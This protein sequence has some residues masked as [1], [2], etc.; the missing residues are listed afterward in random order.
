[1]GSYP[2]YNIVKSACKKRLM[3]LGMD[4]GTA[5]VLAR[6][7]KFW[8]PYGDR[9][10]IIETDWEELYNIFIQGAF[11][12]GF[13]VDKSIKESHKRGFMDLLSQMQTQLRRV[14]EMRS[15]V[16]GE[17][18]GDEEE[19]KLNWKHKLNQINNWNSAEIFYDFLN[20]Q[21]NPWGVK[22]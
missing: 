7:R 9:K 8:L 3:D 18:G 5:Q 17:F 21:E 22:S 10:P 12:M 14:A 4:E 16:G 2:N 13:D 15:R 19:Y 20:W 11:P 1:M 6:G